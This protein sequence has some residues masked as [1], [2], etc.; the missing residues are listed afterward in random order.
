MSLAS[1]Y[2]QKCL[3]VKMTFRE[4]RRAV[5]NWTSDFSDSEKKIVI[6]EL[7]DFFETRQLQ[8][9]QA[10][11]Q[12]KLKAGYDFTKLLPRNLLLYLFSFLDASALLCL[13]EVSWYCKCLAD[14]NELWILKCREMG[15]NM[16]RASEKQM[17]QIGLWKRFYL[18]CQKEASHSVPIK[19]IAI[20]L[21]T[22]TIKNENLKINSTVRSGTKFVKEAF[23]RCFT[24]EPISLP[25]G[26]GDQASF[27]RNSFS[28]KAFYSTRPSNRRASERNHGEQA[29]TMV[30]GLRFGQN[31]KSH[32][33]V[34][35]HPLNTG[36]ISGGFSGSSLSSRSKSFSAVQSTRADQENTKGKFSHLRR[37]RTTS[38]FPFKTNFDRKRRGDNSDSKTV[39]YAEVFGAP[40]PNEQVELQRDSVLHRKSPLPD[41]S[42]GTAYDFSFLR[43]Q[44]AGTGDWRQWNRP[45]GSPCSK[46]IHVRLLRPTRDEM[47]S[48]ST[49]QMKDTSVSPFQTPK[50]ERP[51]DEIRKTESQRVLTPVSVTLSYNDSS[52][53]ISDEHVGYPMDLLK[54]DSQATIVSSYVEVPSILCLP[55]E[56]PPNPERRYATI[57]SEASQCRRP[58][59]SSTSLA[60]PQAEYPNAMVRTQ[61]HR[62]H[63]SLSVGTLGSIGS[64]QQTFGTRLVINTELDA[65]NHS[66]SCNYSYTRCAEAD[67]SRSATEKLTSWTNL[68]R[69]TQPNREF[70][71]VKEVDAPKI[72][73][74]LLF[75][76]SCEDQQVQSIPKSQKIMQEA[77]VLEHIVLP[78]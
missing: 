14:S 67:R 5:K 59:H 17:M 39:R 64:A 27:T 42:V 68:A 1:H 66:S 13:S 52:P 58:V 30:Y 37:T 53:E 40:F 51:D 33:C 56:D 50:V 61:I 78:E 57:S 63:G 60:C 11:L 44:E 10:I 19:K 71:E 75:T 6:K 9:L 72:A 16:P 24:E 46:H 25:V 45:N 22:E 18:N 74:P 47:T 15:W 65:Q 36:S 7:L 21:K 41:E 2:A 48:T 23:T 55:S 28:G 26:I 49:C 77:A 20:R 4:E 3:K 76:A 62:R 29:P 8:H 35:E 34:C 38:P 12:R 69:C 73:S 31:M 54:E 43:E 32:H 70:K